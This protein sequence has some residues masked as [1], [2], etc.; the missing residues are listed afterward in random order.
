[1]AVAV[2]EQADRALGKAEAALDEIQGVLSGREVGPNDWILVAEVL[3][4]TGRTVEEPGGDECA[5]CHTRHVKLTASQREAI[6]ALCER[7]N[8]KFSPC[9]YRPSFDLPIGYVGGMVARL[10]F[11]CSADGRISS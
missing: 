9:S 7:Y 3:R 4:R 8:E 6:A 2:L 1:M 5:I 10:V 11:G